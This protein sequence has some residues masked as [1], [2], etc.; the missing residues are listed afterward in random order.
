MDSYSASLGQGLL[1]YLAVEKKRQGLDL[2]ALRDYVQQT[3]PH[4]CHWFTVDDLN[5]LRRGGRLSGT[6]ALLGTMLGIKPVLHTDDAGRLVAVSKVR[7]RKAALKALV[8]KIGETGLAPLEE[9]T[10]FICQADCLPEAEQVA[11]EIRRRYHVKDVFIDYI[12]PVIG[13][14]TGPGTMGLFFLGSRR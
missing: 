5:F 4:L 3:I 11:S 6:S 8:D 9:Q 13:S 7:G 10:M 1:L 2:H 14:H 12:G